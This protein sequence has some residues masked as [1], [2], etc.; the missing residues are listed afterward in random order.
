[1]LSVIEFIFG[2]A[3]A[4][5]FIFAI[6]APG[7]LP[8]WISRTFGPGRQG[9]VFNTMTFVFIYATLAYLTLAVIYDTI[10]KE[11]PLPI[12]GTDYQTSTTEIE[13]QTQEISRESKSKGVLEEFNLIASLDDIGWAVL[14][15]FMFLLFELVIHEIQFVARVL[16][17]SRLTGQLSGGNLLTKIFSK[18]IESK[19]FVRIRDSEKKLIFTGWVEGYSEHDNFCELHLSGVEVHDFESFLISK[20]E[21][22]YLS[23]PN[24]NIWIDFFTEERRI[25]NG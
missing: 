23:L 17:W 13:G 9:V 15:A 22:T 12:L 6:L 14:I 5:F 24:D 25:Y 8:T 4:I 20:S 7:I 18:V 11:F 21:T 1:M 19:S 16:N 3:S 10:D 2:L